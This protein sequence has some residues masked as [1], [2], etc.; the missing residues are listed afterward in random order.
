MARLENVEDQVIEIAVAHATGMRPIELFEES[1][2]GR[3]VHARS[4]ETGVDRVWEI[5]PGNRPRR[6]DDDRA[7]EQQGSYQVT[8]NPSWTNRWKF[9]CPVALRLIRPKS[10][11]DVSW[12]YWISSYIGLLN[13]LNASMRS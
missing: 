3:G 5:R 4:L 8:R 12:L 7:A 2:K 1:R 13:R 6:R 9:D 10:A 11:E